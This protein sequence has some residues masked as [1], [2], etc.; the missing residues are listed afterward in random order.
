MPRVRDGGRDKELLT[1]DQ[2][3][4][5]LGEERDKNKNF[6]LKMNLPMKFLEYMDIFI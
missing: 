3:W 2:T 5:N 4:G 6:P 1:E